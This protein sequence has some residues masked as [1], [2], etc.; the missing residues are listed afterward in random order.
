[1]TE[2]DN[3]SFCA[4]AGCYGDPVYCGT[5]SEPDIKALKHAFWEMFY[6]NEFDEIAL[7]FAQIDGNDHPVFQKM[8]E[9]FLR[10]Y[11]P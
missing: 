5:C 10:R 11:N 3:G 9:N 1:M 6:H 7:D 4:T 2:H 8:A